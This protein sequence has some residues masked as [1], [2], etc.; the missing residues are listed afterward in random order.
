MMPGWSSEPASKADDVVS[1][2]TWLSG[3]NRQ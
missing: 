2:L 1:Y 3:L